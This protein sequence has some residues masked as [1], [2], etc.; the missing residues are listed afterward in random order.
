MFLAFNKKLNAQKDSAAAYKV[1]NLD[2]EACRVTC[3]VCNAFVT[4]SSKR[5]LDR[6]LGTNMHV[7]GLQ[8]Q[9]LRYEIQQLK[10]EVTT[11]KSEVFNLKGTIATLAPTPFTEI[12]SNLG[13]SQ[14]SENNIADTFMA[15]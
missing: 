12:Q 9:L 2:S 3:I 7:M 14:V 10:N 1:F 8:N 15:S 11:I 13:Y 5:D 6:H 4:Y